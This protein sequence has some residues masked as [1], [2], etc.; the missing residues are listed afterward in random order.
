MCFV[1]FSVRAAKSYSAQNG[2]KQSGRNDKMC[3]ADATNMEEV[4]ASYTSYDT[5]T[6]EVHPGDNQF[7]RKQAMIKK[8]HVQG[9]T[10][11]F[12]TPNARLN[13][14]QPWKIRVPKV[15][16]MD[17]E[18]PNA[19]VMTDH[20]DAPICMEHAPTRM[21]EKIMDA[22]IFV[23][24]NTTQV[25]GAMKRLVQN[26]V[27]SGCGWEP[28]KAPMGKVGK[29]GNWMEVKFGD[30]A[31]ARKMV[32]MIF[33]A[34]KEGGSG[35]LEGV[36]PPDILASTLDMI[37]MLHE[38]TVIGRDLKPTD[39]QISTFC[40]LCKKL[41]WCMVM[42]YPPSL[43]GGFYFHTMGNHASKYMR[44]WKTMGRDSQ[45]SFEK[46]QKVANASATHTQF[47]GGV[48]SRYILPSGQEV[49]I[50]QTAVRGV[51][52]RHNR[53][54]VR[55]C[56]P[57]CDV[58]F[59]KT[60]TQAA[61]VD[62]LWKSSVPLSA[63][64][65]GGEPQPHRSSS[66][67]SNSGE[68]EEQPTAPA[69]QVDQV[70]RLQ[71]V[72]QQLA[73]STATRRATR[74]ARQ[75]TTLPSA[76]TLRTSARAEERRARTGGVTGGAIP[77]VAPRRQRPAQEG[78]SA[79]NSASSD[80]ATQLTQSDDQ[81]VNAARMHTIPE[82]CNLPG[83]TSPAPGAKRSSSQRT[84]GKTAATPGTI[85]GRSRLRSEDATDI[86]AVARSLHLDE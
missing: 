65:P 10:T 32:S 17:R 16:E 48:G 11:A 21:F 84:P 1:G 45:S 43:T 68:S 58:Q 69:R 78:T 83:A 53:V 73:H 51:M 6:T 50:I 49:R 55:E 71:Q 4:F 57:H 67:N 25:R 22:I 56:L 20:L 52:E 82:E 47:G 12:A 36:L 9:I 66:S 44:H 5:G 81:L 23:A 35:W 86:D 8:E 34:K 37:S 24:D 41:H 79:G 27:E 26:C 29:T 42:T 40:N 54:L 31:V 61:E 62:Y 80:A 2:F 74:T 33:N 59:L 7:S 46:N 72:D 15:W 77:R 18:C 30:H 85:R 13:G 19:V 75:P 3:S 14:R 76:P 38:I 39:Q 28:Y 60:N 70:G 64:Q 63:A